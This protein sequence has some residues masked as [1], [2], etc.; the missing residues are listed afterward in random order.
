VLLVLG[1]CV[2]QAG[3]FRDRA[4]LSLSGRQEELFFRLKTLNIPILTILV[5]T[6]PL[7]FPRVAEGSNAVMIAFNGGMFGGEVVA[8]AVFGKLNPSGKLPI[9]FPHHTGQIP[10][11]YNS[12]P[13]WHGG[14]YVDQ[15]PEPLFSFGEGFGYARFVYQNLRFD[16]RSL[17]LSVALSNA[18]AVR[19]AETAQVYVRDLV[20][21]VLTPVKRLVAFQKVT[22]EPGETRE[23]SFPLTRGD[24]SLVKAD[25]R[26]VVENGDFVLMA[27]SSS[28]D[29]DLL[30]LTFRLTMPNENNA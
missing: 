1:D 15:P 9:S 28:K 12:L 19:G 10:V 2:E 7:C 30:T 25:E 21:S 5:S 17:T 29:A 13:G 18:G 3:E 16:E 4:D 11:Y 6:K 23:L 26:R 24:F 27:G 8:K 20:S 22:L 14:K